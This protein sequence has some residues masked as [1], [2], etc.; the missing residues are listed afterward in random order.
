MSAE[1]RIITVRSQNSGLRGYKMTKHMKNEH[2][3]YTLF[4]FVLKTFISIIFC[5]SL[6]ALFS[7][8]TTTD[9]KVHFTPIVPTIYIHGY[10]GVF[11]STEHMIQAA[12]KAGAA[13]KVLIAHVAADGKVTYSGTWDFTQKNPIIQ[14]LFENNTAEIPEEAKWLNTVVEHLKSAYAISEFNLV[15]HSMGGPVTLYWALHERTSS[16]PILKK[17]VPIAG[18]FNGVIYIDD[19]PNTNSFASDGKPKIQDNAYRAYYQYRMRFPSETHILNIYGNLEDGSNS[20]SLVTNVSAKSLAYL[21][22]SHVASYQELMIK[23]TDAQHSQL[24][25]NAE[26]NRAV[27]KFL[28][29]R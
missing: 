9:N 4:P 23:G 14:V 27:I 24:H 15:S 7:N 5:G 21:L 6:L 8:N 16:S 25:N 26:V 11:N 22:K 28:W 1:T 17:F 29:N 2:R 12:E 20:D 3:N 10:G 19:S 18:P 13:K